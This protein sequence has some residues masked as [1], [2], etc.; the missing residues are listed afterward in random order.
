MTDILHT[1]PDFPIK[2]YT[3]LIPSLERKLITTTDLLTLEPLEIARRAQLPLL[4][5]RRLTRHVLA[6]LQSQLGLLNADELLRDN[7]AHS[8]AVCAPS[9][10]QNGSAIVAKWSLIATLDPIFDSALSGGI[11]TGYIT[12]VT[13]ESGAGKTQFLLSLLITAQLPSPHGL[14]R[15]TVYISTEHPLPTPRLTQILRTHPHL[16]NLPPQ[17]KPSLSRIFSIQTPD[18]ESQDHILAYQ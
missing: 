17:Q 4:D 9:L 8:D 15:P 10:S 1:L 13:G 11:P 16:S 7:E 18:L 14:S 2:F 6:R 3:H 5:V 12:E